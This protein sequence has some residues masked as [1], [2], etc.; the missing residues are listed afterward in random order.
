[1]KTLFRITILYNTQAMK[2]YFIGE[3][4]MKKRYLYITGA[5]VCVLC[6]VFLF[7]IPCPLYHI[8]G[9]PCPTCGMT[10]AYDALLHGDIIGAFTMHPL[11]WIPPTVMIIA[12]FHK[13]KIG[14]LFW[15][16]FGLISLIVL[17]I[18]VY[19]IRMLTMFPQTSPMNFNTECAILSILYGGVIQ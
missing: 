7:T 14:R 13:T 5:A 3:T 18:S 4:K 15:S 12:L 1:M 10:R 17:F 16:K 2:Q 6:L 19:V 11:W 8:F 9:I